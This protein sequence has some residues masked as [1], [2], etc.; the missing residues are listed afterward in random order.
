M[1]FTS[2]CFSSH[3]IKSH[4]HTLT[5][6]IP[7]HLVITKRGV[8]FPF[9]KFSNFALKKNAILHDMADDMG[10]TLEE[11]LAERSGMHR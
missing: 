11:E 5:A 6:S 7:F 8:S 4:S 9:Q 3:S 10:I 2:I 1:S